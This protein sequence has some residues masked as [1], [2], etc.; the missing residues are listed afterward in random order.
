VLKSTYSG[1][2]GSEFDCE[3]HRG[4][5][6]FVVPVPGDATSH[7]TLSG[8]YIHVIHIHTLRYTHVHKHTVYKS[9][10]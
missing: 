4:S 10:K 6:L 3:H 8:Y 1:C 7:L 2:K 5:Q 9:I